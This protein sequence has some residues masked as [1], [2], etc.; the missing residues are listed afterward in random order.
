MKYRSEIDG[1]RAVAVISV[2][3]FHAGFS[4]FSGGFVGV[5]IFFVISGY[6]IAT[7]ILSEM[8]SG[9][10]LLI[11]FYERRARRI[12]PALFFVMLI[13]CVLAWFLLMPI[14]MKGFSQSLI[15]VSTFSSNLLFL[16]EAGYWDT[17]SELK[18][19]LHTWSLAVE[20]QYY[21]F[22]PIFLMLMWRFK[23]NWTFG[24]LVFLAVISFVMAQRGAYYKPSPTFFLLSTRAWELAIGAGI[25][26]YF[27]YKKQ[28]N[29]NF[30]L[31][32]IADEIIG[33]LGFL[34]I[35]YAI[36]SFDK[37]TPFP[38]AFTLIPTIG[39]GLI[40]IFS[41]A[42][43]IV[44][45]LLSVKPFVAI[46]LISY[47]AYLWHQPLLAFARHSV[48]IE[49]SHFMYTILALFSFP[50]AYLT[51]RYVEQPFRAKNQ[52]S[53]KSIFSYSIMGSAAF[54]L[55]GCAGY[56]TNGFDGRTKNEDFSADLIEYKL[57]PNYG[58]SKTCEGKFTL[59]PDC[60]TNDKPE[61]LIWGDS[62]AMHLVQGIMAS[63][64]DAKIIQM[65]KSVCGP[66]F[67]IAPIKPPTNPV[68]Y[69][70][71]CLNFN[72]EVRT[73][74]E[75]NKTV[76][77]AVL[78]SPFEQYLSKDSKFLSRSGEVFS[79]DVQLVTQE[80]KATLN[81][82]QQLGVTP[83]VF[84]PP[85]ANG[86]D[87]GRCLAK[88]KWYGS[89][90]NHCDFDVSTIS[91]DRLRVYEFL[92]E[93]KKDHSVIFLSDLLCVNSRCV[94]HFDDVFIFRDTGHLSK[95]GSAVVGKKFDFYGMIVDN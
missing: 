20:E 48:L 67:D 77:Y 56:F 5:D 81:E 84:S 76:K 86:S 70:K 41:S 68:R 26:F 64:P 33:L 2:I 72:A 24:V 75:S 38:S 62:Y 44:G 25:A 51:W 59:S 49:P 74:L 80:F 50:L 54:I 35:G 43:T 23:K 1:L 3:F 16:R 17:A 12:L 91:Q 45:R 82:L 90:L 21:V 6:L 27:V 95:E 18:P 89:S 40:I 85:P 63:K 7:I 4:I 52:F 32:R 30:I 66:F 28:T 55:I 8:E 36:F 73:W 13:S 61:I 78:A 37:N 58:L 11:N 83:I 22:F 15:A 9:S 46:G 47:S 42:Q 69:G 57:S 31:H 71:D 79:T 10:F 93:I 92:A 19:L 65:T 34:M 60:R 94:T 29:K 87:L 14:D 53:R 88:A 39:T